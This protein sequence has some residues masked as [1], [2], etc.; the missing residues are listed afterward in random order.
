MDIMQYFK[1]PVTDPVLVFTIVLLI[2]LL[3]PLILRKFKVPSIVGFIIAG[4]LVGPYGLKILERNDAIILFGTVG[5]IYIMFLAGLDLDFNEFKK[6]RYKSILFGFFTFTIPFFIG[7]PVCHHILGFDMT[8]SILI[9]SMFST[10]TL[11]AYPIAS[12]LGI[13]RNEAVMLAV[14]GTIITD[15]LVLLILAVIIRTEGSGADFT[16]WLR[17][18]VSLVVFG[19]IVFWGFPKIA[20]WFLKHLESEKTIQYIF[21]LTLLFVAAFLSKLAGIE[22]ILGAFVAGITLNRFIPHSS[23]LMNRIEFVGNALFIPFFLISVGMM[24]DLRVLFNGYEAFKVI[25]VLTSVALI[26]KWLA[27]FFTQKIFSF[28]A[29]QRKVIFGL[30]SSHAA[31]TLAVITIGFNIGLVNINVLNGTIV[32]V[33]ITCLVASFVT[34]KGGRNLAKSESSKATEVPEVREKILVSIYN[35][36]TIER[37]ID[38]AI[39]LKDKKSPESIYPL[40]VVQDDEEAKEKIQLSNK[41]LEKAII[42]ASTSDHKVQIITRIDINVSSGISRTVKELLITCIIMGWSEKTKATDKIF[43]TL[44][45]N[46]LNNCSQMLWVCSIN[47]PLNTIRRTVVLIPPNGEYEIGFIK[48]FEKINYLSKQVGNGLSVFCNED[49]RKNILKISKKNDFRNDFKS[50]YFDEWNHFAGV[51]ER[52]EKD[53][54]L[55]IISA[56]Q[57]TISYQHA[58]HNLPDKLNH[59]FGSLNFI[60]IY[61]EQ[62]P[63][64]STVLPTDDMNIGTLQENID[65]IGK[66]GKFIGKFFKKLS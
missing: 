31:A 48:L 58:L 15:V 23:A 45:T 53:Y 18:I 21:V 9:S 40:T 28:S 3:A 8:P 10:H 16:F 25:V 60:L 59:L 47:Q 24:V 62:I 2:I 44:L 50:V 27:A 46:I 55:L 51:R 12:R 61:P 17:L 4:V 42:H 66:L 30:S 41:M 26:G 57:G 37:L 63:N 52:I 14:G 13:T 36:S 1:L 39:L 11:V 64:I 32:L 56:R 54:L 20:R 6:S 5:L 34:D 22:P 43:G 7:I 35:P 49:T 65:Q 33:F 19:L 29:N 38:L